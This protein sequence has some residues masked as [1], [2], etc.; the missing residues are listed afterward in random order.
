[1]IGVKVTKSG[2]DLNFFAVFATSWSAIFCDLS[3]TTWES[4]SL[5]SVA[6]LIQIQVPLSS[7]SSFLGNVFFLRTSM[8]RPSLLLVSRRLLKQLH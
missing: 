5:D 7:N 8:L 6:M 3:P 2:I 4:T 1:M